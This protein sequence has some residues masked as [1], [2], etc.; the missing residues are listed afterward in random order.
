MPSCRGFF[1]YF[2]SSN[3][4]MRT[5]DGKPGHFM[6]TS[7]ALVRYRF[8]V[9]T[10][11]RYLTTLRAYLPYFTFKLSSGETSVCNE[12]FHTRIYRH[13][14]IDECYLH[15]V[16]TVFHGP[17]RY[18]MLDGFAAVGCTSNTSCQCLSH[19]SEPERLTHI[20]STF[21]DV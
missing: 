3:T 7:T 14:L 6:P 21:Q 18:P 5:T 9:N 2:Y 17:E 15:V 20:Q 13:K 4:E 1:Y 16:Y 19:F 8:L 12:S 11:E 10:Y